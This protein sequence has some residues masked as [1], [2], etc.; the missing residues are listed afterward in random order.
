MHP[1]LFIILCIAVV[2]IAAKLILRQ[3]EKSDAKKAQKSVD[4]NVEWQIN[5]CRFN[6]ATIEML[7]RHSDKEKVA[8]IVST[9]IEDYV[10]MAV[11]PKKLS[12]LFQ[13]LGLFTAVRNNWSSKEIELAALIQQYTLRS[14]DAHDMRVY[15]TEVCADRVPGFND[16]NKSFLTKVEDNMLVWDLK[17]S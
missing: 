10:Q 17:L 8:R 13:N 15:Q 12:K 4:E 1:V 2:A 3:G 5:E 14:L 6:E 9:R 7:A 16:L 11:H